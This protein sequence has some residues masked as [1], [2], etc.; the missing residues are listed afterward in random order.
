MSIV[1]YHWPP[2][3]LRKTCQ[4]L[5]EVTDYLE[6]PRDMLGFNGV[7]WCCCHE[8][9]WLLWSLELDVAGDLR[10]ATRIL[11]KKTCVVWLFKVAIRSSRCCLVE[12]PRWSKL[13]GLWFDSSWLDWLE[14][15][16]GPATRAIN[17]DTGCLGFIWNYTTPV[18]WGFIMKPWSLLNNQYNGKYSE[19]FF[20]G[21][22]GYLPPKECGLGWLFQR[23]S[24]MT[25]LINNNNNRIH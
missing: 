12:Y 5:L 2:M 16:Y 19:F 1:L 22:Q 18:I 25:H 10:N 21:S 13:N 8:K 20:G 4:Y 17:K 24:H 3:D 15:C 6:E 11:S 9:W 23:G 7:F 14:R